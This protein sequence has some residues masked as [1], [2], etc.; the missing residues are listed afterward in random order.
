[1]DEAFQARYLYLNEIV[2][3]PL[4]EK[5][6][7]LNKY[8]EELTLLS[9]ELRYYKNGIEKL[10]K[11]EFNEMLERLKT[12]AGSKFAVLHHEMAD[13]QRDLEGINTLG[14]E[15]FELTNLNPIL[16]NNS[17]PAPK[18]IV[19]FLLRSRYLQ[20]EAENLIAKPIKT[21]VE[22]YPYD[23]PRELTERKL[24]L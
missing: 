7:K 8:I 9:D 18:A 3:G 23:L 2:C 20:E 4:L 5:R 19:P 15:F 24:I 1:M 16:P 10:T 22:I 14:N 12:S 13:L 11:V 6:D 21:S 17:E